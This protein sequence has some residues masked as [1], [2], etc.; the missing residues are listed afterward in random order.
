MFLHKEL[1]RVLQKNRI[2]RVTPPTKQK[3]NNLILPSNSQMYVFTGHLFHYVLTFALE[4]T[5]ENA[6]R[7]NYRFGGLLVLFY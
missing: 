3:L 4:G 5:L 2:K 7:K 1:Q 6:D